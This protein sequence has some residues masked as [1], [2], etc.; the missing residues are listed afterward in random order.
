MYTNIYLSLHFVSLKY[1]QYN[2]AA[3]FSLI[4]Q[5]EWNDD[6]LTWNPS[7]YDNV[8][9]IV[10]PIETIWVPD[11]GIQNRSMLSLVSEYVGYDKSLCHLNYSRSGK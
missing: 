9:Q 5:K 1:W 8:E 6:Y 7:T 4:Y 3:I 2:L 10:L 11:I